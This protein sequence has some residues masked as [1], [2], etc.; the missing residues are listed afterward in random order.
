MCHLR[1]VCTH[2]G[3]A[4]GWKLGALSRV[5]RVAEQI[6]RP[7]GKC[8]K[9]WVGGGL[10]VQLGA[11]PPL[12]VHVRSVNS[13]KFTVAGV[14]SDIMRRVSLFL[15]NGVERSPSLLLEVAGER[16]GMSELGRR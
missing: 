12:E 14:G 3:P 15:M 13:A 6:C 16:R 10:T 2:S 9:E 1:D 11:G 4:T 8:R 7:G 5:Q